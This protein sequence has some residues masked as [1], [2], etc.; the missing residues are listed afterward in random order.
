M[1]KKAIKKLRRN[2]AIGLKY[3]FSPILLGISFYVP[4]FL[5]ITTKGRK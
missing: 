5:T 2:F 3:S 4:N 1:A